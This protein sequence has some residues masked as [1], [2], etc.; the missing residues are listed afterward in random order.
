MDYLDL[1]NHAEEVQVSIITLWVPIGS[2]GAILSLLYMSPRALYQG[3]GIGHLLASP[4]LVGGHTILST[5]SKNTVT[6]TATT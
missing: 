6:S 1:L 4:L 2:L 5:C 3:K